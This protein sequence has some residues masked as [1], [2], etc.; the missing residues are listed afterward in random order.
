[1]KH[2]QVAAAL[3][4]CH[5]M[6]PS[7]VH[8]D[9]KPENLLLTS[10]EDD[11][12]V[13]IADFGL[14]K[15]LNDDALMQTACGTPGYVAP[16]ILDQIPYDHK[17]DTW[18]LG[19]I[20]YI[21]LCGFPPFYDE[22]NAKLFEKIKSA[23]IDFPSPYWDNVSQEAQEFI[24]ALLRKDPNDVAATETEPA[25]IGR[26]SCAEVK[27]Q[28]WIRTQLAVDPAEAADAPNL[29]N[30]MAQLKNFNAKRKFKQSV[31]KVKL[32]NRMKS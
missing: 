4:Q 27:D 7:I 22:N 11:A 26:I 19:V 9:L 21:L 28:A 8:R 6:T 5:S 18:S 1:M 15:L 20:T 24:L 2:H 3:A 31:M 32:V 12:N 30:A 29:N 13:K 17:V 23:Q 16:E 14:A 25:K 10:T